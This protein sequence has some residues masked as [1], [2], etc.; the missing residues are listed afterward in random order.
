MSL[1]WSPE[2]GR[3]CPG[4]MAWVTQSQTP[5]NEHGNTLV[6]SIQL[7]V[8]QPIQARAR[9]NG[10]ANTGPGPKVR[11]IPRPCPAGARKSAP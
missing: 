5:D 9:T 7:R 6:S 8:C 1:S 11:R 2:P 4:D 3:P 10:L